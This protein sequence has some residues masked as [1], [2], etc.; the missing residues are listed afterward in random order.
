MTYTVN[1]ARSSRKELERLP[2]RVRE[3]IVRLLLALEIEPRPSGR[4]RVLRPPLEGYCLRVG[5]W[6]VLYRVDDEAR[7]V[8]VFSVSH[9]RDAYR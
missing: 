2:P 1:V 4:F 6:R 8:T 7:E 3:A 5:D 9:R